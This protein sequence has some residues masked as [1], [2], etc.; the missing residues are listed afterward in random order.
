MA[1]WEATYTDR[2]GKIPMI[3]AYIFDRL[4]LQIQR[5]LKT[6]GQALPVPDA[7]TDQL[8]RA[9]YGKFVG[10]LK[11]LYDNGITI[12]A[13]TDQGSGYALDREL[14]IYNQSGIPAP[15]VLRMATLTAAQVMRRDNELGSIAPGKLADMILVNGDPTTNIS[16]IR[17]IETVIKGGVVMY[18]KELY[19]AVG[20]R[21]Q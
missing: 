10:M 17:K 12:V 2:P 1:I 13:G 3:D 9:S 5:S 7:A 18:P 6:A 8:Y 11:K 21:A 4:P 19:S 20:I 14:E 15:Q 16:D